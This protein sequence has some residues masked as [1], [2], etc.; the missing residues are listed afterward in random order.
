M[1][2]TYLC[3]LVYFTSYITRLN[4]S[5]ALVEIVNS[6][7]ISNTLGGIP[8]TLSFISYGLGQLIS[9]TL[10]DKFDPKKI[11]T[12]GLII[13]ASV[14]FF[15]VFTNNIYF[16]SF[17]WTINGFAQS[18]L[19]PPLVKTMVHFLN[20]EQYKKSCTLVLIS[21][22]AATILLFIFVPIC[23]NLSSYKLVFL[24]SSMAGFIVSFIWAAAVKHIEVSKT[25]PSFDKRNELSLFQVI[26][27]TGLIPIMV[28]IIL[29]GILRDGITT[30]MPTFINDVFN[31]STSTSILISSLLPVFSIMSLIFARMIS[32]KCN[33][34]ILL[35]SY[36]W[37]SSLVFC[38]ILFFGI[39]IIQIAVISMSLLVASLHVINLLLIGN[40]PAKFECY[41]K[42]STISGL[43]NFCVYIGS[44]LSIYGIAKIN[45]L[46]G[47]NITIIIWI[48]IIIL[49]F[50][51]SLHSIIFITTFEHHN[52]GG[53]E[54]EK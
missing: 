23:L 3:C 15:I 28:I 37:L 25:T 40:L 18:L 35:S 11:I 44:A 7:S 45:E 43:L 42:V 8:V 53:K 16:I 32:K 4:Y 34:E 49:G 6:L 31:K 26:K 38:V 54:N 36:F 24:F 41:N 17:L 20:P 33:N 21:A 46:W 22:S 48:I 29:H 1:K 51:L 19:W 2:F 9:G 5:V 39:N 47:W 30:W 52:T 27:S 13:T 10:G 50:L 14:N 12:T